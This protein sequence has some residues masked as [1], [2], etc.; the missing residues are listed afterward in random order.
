MALIVILQECVPLQDPSDG[1]SANYGFWIRAGV[2]GGVVAVGMAAFAL[3]MIPGVVLSNRQL[4]L[5]CIGQG[6]C[7][8]FAALLVA[9][10]WVFPIPFMILTIISV[11]VM[12]FALL[13]LLVAG[14]EAFSE[15]AKHPDELILTVGFSGSQSVMAFV[16]AG[17]AV[18]FAHVAGTHFEVPVILLLS[19]IKIIMKNLVSRTIVHMKDMVPEAVIFTVDFFNSMYLAT[20]MQNASSISTVLTM[21]TID[22]TQTIFEL[23]SLYYRTNTIVSRLHQAC[24]T[25]TSC[26]CLLPAVESL[27]RDTSKFALQ[28]R[29]NVI[30]SSC[31]PHKLSAET[32]TLLETLKSLPGNGV[33]TVPRMSTADFR[34]S[35]RSKIEKA[36]AKSIWSRSTRKIEPGNDVTRTSVKPI[37][38]V[39]KDG[40]GWLNVASTP[41]KRILNETLEVLFTTECVVLTEYLESIIPVLY[42]NFVLLFV[43]LPSARYHKDLV[44]ITPDNVGSTVSNIFIYAALEF[45]SFIFLIF[46]MMR[47]CRLKAL[48]HLAFVLETQMLLVQVKLIT[49]VLM[50]LSFRVEH[51]GT[52]AYFLSCGLLLTLPSLAGADFTFGFAWM[53]HRG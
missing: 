12:V 31:L 5:L 24:G 23:R 38:E 8:P 11:Y 41:H 53:S 40:K 27:C 6:V 30:I 48:Y 14:K 9:A 43:H 15:M 35:I 47:N 2:L 13:F 46:M 32:Q 45:A 34:G 4:V 49:W 28:A 52:L 10:L 44:G 33:R 29:E 19:I 3:Y 16:Y 39:T 26:G 50:S 37:H 17:Y 42:A 22:I 7:Y 25:L 18:L 21:M 1:W 20:S 51:F 36:S